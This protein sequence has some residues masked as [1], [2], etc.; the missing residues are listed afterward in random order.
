[1]SPAATHSVFALADLEHSELLPTCAQH[2]QS[3]DFVVNLVGIVRWLALLPVG[4]QSCNKLLPIDE[5]F[6]VA[7]EQIRYGSHL[8]S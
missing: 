6:A 4:P 1:M 3:L 7:I 8:H 5:S 2:H